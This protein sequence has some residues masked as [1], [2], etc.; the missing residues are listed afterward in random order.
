[1]SPALRSF[2]YGWN[3]TE[4]QISDSILEREKLNTTEDIEGSLKGSKVAE[5]YHSIQN[6]QG[7]RSAS[8]QNSKVPASLLTA[9]WQ[10]RMHPNHEGAFSISVA[11]RPSLEHFA[12]GPVLCKK[13]VRMSLQM[14]SFGNTFH[15]KLSCVVHTFRMNTEL[16]KHILQAPGTLNYWAVQKEERIAIDGHNWDTNKEHVKDCQGCIWTTAV[17]YQPR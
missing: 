2:G 7:Q 8:Q 10:D 17:S 4:W 14:Q 15:F 11:K 5:M 9:S 13:V 1:M 16:F 12:K 3:G 6:K